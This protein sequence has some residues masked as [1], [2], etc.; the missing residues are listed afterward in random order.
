[1][2]YPTDILSTRAVV[3]HGVYAIIPPTGLVNNVVPG[4]NGCTISVLASPKM[5]AG[6]VQYLIEATQGG[7]YQ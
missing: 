7:G 3:K 1:M 5:G 2:P 6:F 4:I